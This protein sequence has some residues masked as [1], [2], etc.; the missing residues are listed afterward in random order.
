MV[1]L[2]DQ[3]A[4]ALDAGFTEADVNAFLGAGDPADTHQM[5][6]RLANGGWT[7]LDSYNGGAEEVGWRG[8]YEVIDDRHRG[9]QGSRHGDH[10]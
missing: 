6:L 4:T 3:I 7:Q 8:T 10:L 5:V 9:R 1:T 2:D